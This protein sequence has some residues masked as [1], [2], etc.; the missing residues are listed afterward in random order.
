MGSRTKLHH[1]TNPKFHHI[2]NAKLYCVKEATNAISS[3]DR[4]SGLAPLGTLNPQA[5]VNTLAYN[6]LEW[7]LDSESSAIGYNYQVAYH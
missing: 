1:V 6:C 2:V 5:L 3:R 7:K 4:L